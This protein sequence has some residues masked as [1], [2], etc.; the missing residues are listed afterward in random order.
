MD[1]QPLRAKPGIQSAPPQPEDG[2]PQTKNKLV[3]TSRHASEDSSPGRVNIVVPG[4]Q[5]DVSNKMKLD[6]V[7]G[8]DTNSQHKLSWARAVQQPPKDTNKP[9][10]SSLE[11][12]SP[13]RGFQ[14]SSQERKSIL[15][16][17][18]TQNGAPGQRDIQ[19]TSTA[20]HRIRSA[21][22]TIP[23][24]KYLVYV[25]KLAAGTTRDDLQCHLSDNGITNMY[26]IISLNNSKTFP[27]ETSFCV[28]L[29]DEASMLKLFDSD[30][31]PSGVNVRPF[32]PA[33][34]SRHGNPGNRQQ[35]LH[36]SSNSYRR[37]ST[38]DSNHRTYHSHP[39]GRHQGRDVHRWRESTEWDA[40]YTDQ[41]YGYQYYG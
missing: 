9:Q 23:N 30:M 8:G 37:R 39:V 35:N 26:D 10:S 18:F 32:R 14:H 6:D 4:P 5:G 36:T 28:S 34:P 15:K 38:H 27:R 40:D 11:K 13:A 20:S 41:D 22:Q 25:G 17:N 7:N 21:T 3:A 24:K 12:S 2:L 19:G 16:G 33:R 31:W 29:G 1:G